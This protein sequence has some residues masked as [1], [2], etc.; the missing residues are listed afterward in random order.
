M[1]IK[2]YFRKS[3]RNIETK[4]QP[5]NL[6]IYIPVNNPKLSDYRLKEL[7]DKLLPG[8]VKR[9]FEQ[10]KDTTVYISPKYE[11][12]CTGIELDNAGNRSYK[13]KVEGDLESV[14]RTNPNNAMLRIPIRV[15]E[16]IPESISKDQFEEPLKPVNTPSHWYSIL[17][18]KQER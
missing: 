15:N 4:T 5:L 10:E 11:V 13:M 2:I 3:P 14:V 7:T 9:Q 12:R 16:S 6:T 1:T 17:K 8:E 18:P